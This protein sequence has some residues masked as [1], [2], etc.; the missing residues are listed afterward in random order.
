MIAWI[1]GSK[2]DPNLSD[3]HRGCHAARTPDLVG[4]SSARGSALINRASET[5]LTLYGTGASDRSLTVAA[6]I[7]SGSGR[8]GCTLGSPKPAQSPNLM[9]WARGSSVE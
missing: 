7:Y 3:V 1:L 6:L 8:L 4:T 2:Y 9:P 5:E